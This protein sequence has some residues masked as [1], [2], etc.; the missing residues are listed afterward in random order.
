MLNFRLFNVKCALG[1]EQAIQ[2]FA[3][4]L[5]KHFHAGPGPGSGR[6]NGDICGNSRR[7][8]GRDHQNTVSDAFVWWNQSNGFLCPTNGNGRFASLALT[9]I[10]I[11]TIPMV[12]A[13]FILAN[14]KWNFFLSGVM[15]VI[16]SPPSVCCSRLPPPAV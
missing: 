14:V 5:N 2:D 8:L 11:D 15:Q 13:Y 7:N 16:L 3:P 9:R 6:G 4:L 10:S 1:V 12:T